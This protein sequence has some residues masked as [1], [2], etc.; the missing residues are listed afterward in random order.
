MN[1][2]RSLTE[3]LAAALVRLAWTIETVPDEVLEPR[4]AVLW[5]ESLAD[6]LSGMTAEQSAEFVRVLQALPDVVPAS[7]QPLIDAASWPHLADPLE[8]C[9]RSSTS[10]PAVG[11]SGASDGGEGEEVLRASF[12]AAGE[13]PVGADPTGAR[14]PRCSALPCVTPAS[15][16]KGPQDDPWS[17]A[18]PQRTTADTVYDDR[19]AAITA[20]ARS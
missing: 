6:D 5:L 10:E 18:V 19:F 9:G 14:A 8:D 12:T 3:V 16:P 2:E 15:S 7:T 11:D 4:F 13:A 17:P 20:A 1:D